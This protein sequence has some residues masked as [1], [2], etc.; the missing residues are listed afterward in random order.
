MNKYKQL[1][2]Q[3]QIEIQGI[4]DKLNKLNPVHTIEFDKVAYQ[5]ML[6]VKDR[7]LCVG[8]LKWKLPDYMT[9]TTNQLESLFYDYFGLVMFENPEDDNKLV[10]ARFANTGKLSEYGILNDIIPIDFAGKSYP[11]MQ[12]VLVGG[13]ITKLDPTKP[14][15]VAVFDYT[16]NTQ[17]QN[18]MSRNVINT[19]TTIKSQV[20]V[21]TQMHNNIVLSIKKAIALCENEDQKHVMQNQLAELL[22][23]D[24]PIDAI[25]KQKSKGGKAIND[26]PVEMFNFDNNFDTQNYTQTIDFYDKVRRSFNGIPAPDTFE[27]KERKITVESENVVVHTNMVLYDAYMNRKQSIEL[28]KKL[29][30]N[31]KNKVLD[32]EYGDIL[33]ELLDKDDD[34]NYNKNEEENNDNIDKR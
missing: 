1:Y 34:I 13:D 3:S 32:V 31:E 25:C 5:R 9:L 18:D 27:K 15:G 28:F 2:L 8:R 33:S 12:A 16:T 23:T 20:E 17:V 7:I 30:K 21:Y 10:F 24:T 19:N 22:S 29:A 11:A 4:I 14:F 26:M 6:S